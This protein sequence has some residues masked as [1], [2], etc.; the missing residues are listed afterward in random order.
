MPTAAEVADPR[1]RQCLLAFAS[2]FWLAGTASAGYR[3]ARAVVTLNHSVW[4][5]APADV[6]D[7]LLYRTDS[8]WAGA[9]RGLARGL[10]YDRAGRLVAST[11]QEIQL[12]LG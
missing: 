6:G 4:F 5:H 2:D 10:I 9:G 11:V 3:D 12:S 8:P 1:A 7:W